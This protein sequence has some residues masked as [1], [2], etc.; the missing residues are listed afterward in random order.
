MPAQAAP[1]AGWSGD[2]SLG[3]LL[4]VNGINAATSDAAN[5]I[6]LDV[7]EPILINVTVA[8]GTALTIHTAKFTM[9]YMSFPIIDPPASVLDQYLP[10]NAT[11]V[12]SLL[13]I[14]LAPLFSYANITLIS[15]TVSGSFS[16]TYSNATSPSVN[17]TVS[18]NF[19]LHIGPAGFGVLF[20]VTGLVTIGFAVMAVFS[21][22]LSLDEFQRGILAA[23]KMKGATKGSDVGIFPA[24][25]V[26]RRKPRKG[27][28]SI[29][30]DELVRRV[31][32]SASR[33]WD[34]TRCP[35]CG[36]KWKK[37]APA[38]SKCGID[39]GA[40]VQFFSQGIAEYAPKAL[41][42]IKPK[43]KVTVGQ[44]GKK[45]RL[46]ADKAGALAAALVD[47]GV[48]QTKTVK[49]PL[50]K[51]AFAGLS[52][53]GIYW[54]IMQMF[55][56]A[57][58]DLVTELLTTTAGLVVSVLMGYFMNFLARINSLGYD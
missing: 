53:A 25:V 46:K 55:Y 23:R 21:L 18:E 38:C 54:S 41:K 34:K 37:D 3:L 57:T 50:K 14:S 44:L 1:P 43:S 58:P 47:M 28:E 4:N 42:V 48:L 11:A 35:Q 29:D 31:N 12:Y 20:S 19:V 52:L 27:G 13:P 33:A 5:P 2:D 24:A 6:Q 17:K 51:V 9:T 56:G 22:I 7:S 15:G 26:L 49:V 30:K 40:A 45:L 10:D 32:Q 8:T 39:A 36:K 16:F